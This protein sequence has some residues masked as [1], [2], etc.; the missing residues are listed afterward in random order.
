MLTN[1]S[2]RHP[3]AFLARWSSLA[4][5]ASEARRS[6]LETIVPVLALQEG[7]R[8][9]KERGKAYTYLFVFIYKYCTNSLYIW[10]TLSVGA[11]VSGIGSDR[12]QFHY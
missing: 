11:S 6:A 3:Q 8:I 12:S 7:V 2:A 1:T 9:A 4:V 10:S 5:G